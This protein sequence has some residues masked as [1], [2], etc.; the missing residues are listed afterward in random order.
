MITRSYESQF[1]GI[2]HLDKVREERLEAGKC[3][4]LISFP[5]IP[6]SRGVRAAHKSVEP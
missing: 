5:R 3:E 6:K 1:V 2:F 4:R